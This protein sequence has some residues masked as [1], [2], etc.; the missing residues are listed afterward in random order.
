MKALGGA[1]ALALMGPL[2]SIVHA[3]KEELTPKTLVCPIH[4]W[5][6]VNDR[7]DFESYVAGFIN[8]DYFPVSLKDLA[9]Y[10]YDDIK[11]WPEDKNP[12]A[13]TFDDGLLSQYKNAFPVL[14][15]WKLQATFFVMTDYA[16]GAHEYMEHS[17][18]KEIADKGREVAAHGLDMHRSL[19]TLYSQD[20]DGWIRNVV[21]IKKR[22]EEIIEKPVVSF[23]YPNGSYDRDTL[24]L[25][26]ETGYKIAVRTGGNYPLL[27]S[28]TIFELPR[29]SRT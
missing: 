18:L 6:E 29:V 8:D 1:A 17:H 26:S 16:D 27:S 9:T 5:H 24:D 13:V 7:R 10:F 3:E 20:R 11:V 19:P 4:Y 25:V 14:E 21:G 28:S 2:A 22:L 15:E 12:I 23:A